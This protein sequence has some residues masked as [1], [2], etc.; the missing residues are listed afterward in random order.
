GFGLDD[1]ACAVC[2]AGAAVHYINE[3][4]RAQAAHLGEI[5]YFE[6]SEYLVLD[7]TTVSNLEL[8]TA[9]DGVAAHSLL[10]VI[11]E[12]MTGMGALLIRQWLLRPSV[13]LGEIETRLDAVEELKT[14]AMKRDRLRRLLEALAALERLA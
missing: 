6:P 1:R 13:R 14:S 4:Q 2:A 5:T 10:G 9:N 7:A 3:T 8:V 11:D 12:T